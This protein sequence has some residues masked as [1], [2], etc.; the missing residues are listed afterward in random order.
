[1]RSITRIALGALT[2]LTIVGVSADSLAGGI[3][4]FCTTTGAQVTERWFSTNPL[5]WTVCTGPASGNTGFYS[6]P[7]Y[8]P[9]GLSLSCPFIGT[10]PD[11]DKPALQSIYRALATWNGATVPT[12]GTAA[13]AFSFAAPAI[14]TKSPLVNG[15]AV[16]PVT[17]GGFFPHAWWS[18]LGNGPDG[19][20]EITLWDGP[21]TFSAS[22]GGPQVL[23]VTGVLAVRAT[24]QILEADIAFPARLPLTPTGGGVTNANWCFVEDN[25]AIGVTLGTRSNWTTPT[26]ADPIL[27]Y[28]DLQGVLVHELGHMAGLG[29]SLVDGV[30]QITIS[31]FPTMFGEAQNEPYSGTISV[32]TGCGTY[33][34]FSTNVDST[35]VKGIL[36]LSART[37]ELDDVFALAEGYPLPIG[38]PY[39]SQTGRIT[40]SVIGAPGQSFPGM[41][42]VAVNAA[43]P[44]ALRVGT[45]SFTGGAFAFQGLPP[46]SYYLRLEPVDRISTGYTSGYFTESDVPNYVQ[47]SLNWGCVPFP[48]QQ[49]GAEWFDGVGGVEAVTETSNANAV[50][51]TVTAGGTVSATFRPNNLASELRVSETGSA[52]QSSPRGARVS[53][54]QSVDFFMSGLPANAPTFFCFDLQHTMIPLSPQ[55]GEVFPAITFPVT[56]D[57]SGVARLT[58]VVDPS[59]ARGN[60]MSQG[61]FLDAA[62]AIQL[63]NSVNMWV[64]G[65]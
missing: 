28:A 26:F 18:P 53:P 46:G 13:S 4:R 58:L 59:W 2:A 5:P 45:L 15:V 50:A 60:F 49:F 22:M 23:A 40:G 21:S 11:A 32:A 62:G 7:G 3:E 47:S 19:V 41:S 38:A 65:P 33:A 64:R 14:A 31:N 10:L 1:M 61:L 30:N 39:W 35:L 17:E 43:E 6:A 52:A 42:I 16:L 34:P 24:G 12:V 44:D 51:L 36:G 55:L 25:T 29:H 8:P 56:A 20:N 54:G 57:A 9:I 37:L 48:P 63:T 27:G